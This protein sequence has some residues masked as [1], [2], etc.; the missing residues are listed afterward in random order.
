MAVQP[1]PIQT[2]KVNEIVSCD[3]ATGIE[4]GR[5]PLCSADDVRQAV[6]VAR[7][8]QPAWASQTFRQRARVI[9]QARELLLAERDEIASLISKETGKPVAEA[10]SMEIV[11][12]L[13]SMHYFAHAAE[14]LLKPQKIDIGQYGLMGRTSK[15]IFRPL[16]VIGIISPWNFPLATPADEVVM[17]LMAG[18]SVVLKPSELT[19]LIALKLLDIF[20]RAGL[21][22]GLL[23]VVTGDGSTGAALVD[24]HVDKI[25]FTGSVVTGKRVAEAAAKHLTPV[26]LELGGKDP[27]VVLAD[28]ELEIA[29]RAAVWGAFANSGQACASVERCYAQQTIA[30]KFIE[31]VVAETKKLKQGVGTADDIDV[32]AM[33]NEGQL[34]I[35]A[36]HV[37]DAR[38][39]GAEILTGGRRSPN[40]D[41]LFYEPTVLTNVDHSMI[42]MRD[43]TFGPVLPIMTFATEEEA[44]RLA[45]DSI[46]GLTASVWTKDIGKGCRI[47]ERID[48]GTVMVN[49]VV[50][51]HGIAQTPWG[52][53]KESGYGRTHGRMGLLELVQPYHIHVNRFAFLPDVWWFRYSPRA[54]HL[55]D[56]L[57]KKFTTGSILKTSVLLP[58]MIRR[59]FGRRD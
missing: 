33:S 34:N 49:E 4:V 58:Q 59:L 26:V 36:A 6:H 11:P 25:M 43:E 30:S 3:P 19:P 50:Y 29:A 31:L 1:L 12:T 7:A 21:P 9:L 32:G 23:N 55:F 10:L 13:D 45:N 20:A 48:A 40:F 54:A 22:V 27:M 35:V 18:N 16:G 39:R 14:N 41:G 2:E 28:A 47:A 38:N 24:A 53:V 57:A 37:D 44:I 15:I 17:A 42:I 56:G 5:A 46:F 52:G 8:A 51:T